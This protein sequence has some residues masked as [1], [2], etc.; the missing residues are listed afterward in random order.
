MPTWELVDGILAA[1][2]LPPVTRTVPLGVAIAVGWVLE[3]TYAVFRPDEEPPLTP[4]L[5]RELATSHW[6]DLS[7]A[8][9]DLGYVPQVSIGEGLERLRVALCPGERGV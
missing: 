8:R 5:A 4:F 6:F 2:G 9:R 1:G 3:R 7:A